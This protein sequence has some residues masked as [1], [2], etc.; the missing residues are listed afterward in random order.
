MDLTEADRLT[1]LK[2]P[3]LYARAMKALA[4]EIEVWKPAK[5]KPGYEVSNMANARSVD[6]VIMRSN[7]IPCTRKGQPIKPQWTGYKHYL[8]IERTP[9]ATLILETFVGPRPKGMQVRHFP[10]RTPQNCRLD[11]LRWGTRKQNMTDKLFHGTDARG[12]KSPNSKLKESDIPAIHKEYKKG[13]SV[14]SIAN[15]YAVDIKTI[16]SVLRK[17]SYKNTQPKGKTEL[18]KKGQYQAKLT[19]EQV[20][21]LLDLFKKGTSIPELTKIFPVNR[22]SARSIIEGESYKWV[23]RN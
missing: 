18:Q 17:E 6:R 11:N 7:G 13:K 22:R 10:D 15:T 1:G 12:T 21:N 5:G 16:Y 2:Y 23:K 4:K 20:L 19:N 8:Q 14:K 3:N 9:L